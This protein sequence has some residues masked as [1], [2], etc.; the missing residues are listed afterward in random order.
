MGELTRAKMRLRMFSVCKLFGLVLRIEGK[1]GGFRVRFFGE[2]EGDGKVLRRVREEGE[3][4]VNCRVE[5][6]AGE[7]S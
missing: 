6:G 3:L 7:F 5:R 4:G 1:I 2:G